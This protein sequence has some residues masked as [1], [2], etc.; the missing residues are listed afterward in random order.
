MGVREVGGG[1]LTSRTQPLN[2]LKSSLLSLLW[3]NV[4]SCFLGG[5]PFSLGPGATGLLQHR[6]SE[7]S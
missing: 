2:T 1:V 7:S 4:I 6:I 5:V 3:I